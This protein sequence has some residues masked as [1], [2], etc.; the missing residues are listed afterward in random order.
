[1][2]PFNIEIICSSCFSYCKSLSSISFENDS[3]LRR[4]ESD[5]FFASALES[6]TIHRGVEILSSSCFSYCK[7]LSSISFES[8]ALSW[9]DSAAFAGTVLHFV[10][11]PESVVFI[12]GDAFPRSCEVLTSNI[13]S[14]QEFNEWNE[15]RQSGSREAF[16]WHGWGQP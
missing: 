7:S 10:L 13:D 6:I 4:I 1:M 8:S 3:R 5:A 12:A 16:E 9:I 15:A 2:I 14:C 11:L